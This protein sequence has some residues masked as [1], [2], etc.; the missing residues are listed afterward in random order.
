MGRSS[1]LAYRATGASRDAVEV[2]GLSRAAQAVVRAVEAARPPVRHEIA[3]EAYWSELAGRGSGPVAEAWSRETL[4]RRPNDGSARTVYRRP[5]SRVAGIGRV[6]AALDA[7]QRAQA[8]Q[9]WAQQRQR[10]AE[11]ER[12]EQRHGPQLER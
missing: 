5:C 7:G 8:V 11:R 1:V 6:L 12:Q 2:P 9:E 3:A 4:S 10:E